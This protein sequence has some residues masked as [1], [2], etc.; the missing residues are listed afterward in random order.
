[1]T[2]HATTTATFVQERKNDPPLDEISVRPFCCYGERDYNDFPAATARPSP[3]A[4]SGAIASPSATVTRRAE[5]DST[6]R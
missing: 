2:S 4:L 6:H 3:R 5:E 1:M